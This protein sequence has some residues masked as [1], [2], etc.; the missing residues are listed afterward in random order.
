[1]KLVSRVA[2]ACLAALGLGSIPV[3][4]SAAAQSEVKASAALPVPPKNGISEADITGGGGRYWRDGG[5]PPDVWGCSRACARMVKKNRY[6][7][8]RAAQ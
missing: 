6:R 5:C 8:V 4:V 3:A 2:I 1:M 7:A